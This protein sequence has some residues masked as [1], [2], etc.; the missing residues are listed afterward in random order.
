MQNLFFQ[1]ICRVGIFMIC[2]Q[3]MIH[4]RPQ[5]ALSLIHI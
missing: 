1:T 2:A 3:A 4:F 5:E